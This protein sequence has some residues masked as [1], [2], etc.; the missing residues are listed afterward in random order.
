MQQ[1]I[2]S[3][4]SHRKL[5][6]PALVR[7]TFMVCTGSRIFPH[8]P[9]VT[10]LTSL[11]CGHVGQSGFVHFGLL[12]SRQSTRRSLYDMLLI[13]M[14]EN[15]LRGKAPQKAH[16]IMRSAEGSGEHTRHRLPWPGSMIFAQYSSYQSAPVTLPLKNF[17]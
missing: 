6:R 9:G 10:H 4:L 2:N 17:F 3:H 5:A 15:E 7:G 14:S 16:S 13:C 12:Q 8:R 11:H 1:R